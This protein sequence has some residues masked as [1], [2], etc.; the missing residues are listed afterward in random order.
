VLGIALVV[1][2]LAFGFAAL[3]PAHQEL[4]AARSQY[5]RLERRL[6]QSARHPAG[7]NDAAALEA[8][9]KHFPPHDVARQD[10][11]RLQSVAQKHGIRLRSGEYRFSA[12]AGTGLGRHQIVLPITG[13][14]LNVRAFIAEALAELPSLALDS[15]SFKRDTVAARE[16]EARL[17]FSLYTNA[18]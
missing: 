14:Y 1:F 9:Y 17:Q 5:Q 7:A 15:A 18:A 8:F 16:I 2:A 13:P 11:L 12:D 6:D 4:D 10:L 3:L